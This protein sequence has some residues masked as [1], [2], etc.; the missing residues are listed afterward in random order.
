MARRKL[1]RLPVPGNRH[2]KPGR[3]R[4]RSSSQ[5]DAVLP[6]VGCGET[7][8][9]YDNG[10]FIERVRTATRFHSWNCNKECRVQQ[11][12]RVELPSGQVLR[13]RA[14]DRL[15]VGWRLGKTPMGHLKADSPVDYKRAGAAEERGEDGG[16]DVRPTLLRSEADAPPV[17]AW[18]GGGLGANLD[19]VL[20]GGADFPHRS[21]LGL[22]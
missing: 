11:F 20:H 6:C 18:G 17:R 19:S 5:P 13:L 8:P 21:P 9:R 10:H 1:V 3:D 16:T 22:G 2:R 4:R 14:G 15:E 7:R 12:P